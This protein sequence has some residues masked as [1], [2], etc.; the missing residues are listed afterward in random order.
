MKKEDF[1]QDGYYT[2][3]NVLGDKFHY[4]NGSFHRTDGPSIEFSSGRKEWYCNGVRH[5]ENGPALEFPDG[6]KHWYYKGTLVNVNSQQDF[7]KFIKL[8]FFF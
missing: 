1:I 3:E 7:E 8:I 4:Y 5:R 6:E 2:L